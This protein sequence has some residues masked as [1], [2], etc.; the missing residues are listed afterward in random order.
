MFRYRLVDH[1]ALYQETARADHSA[2]L[3]DG[4]KHLRAA[5]LLLNGIKVAG[6]KT[7]YGANTSTVQLRPARSTAAT[8]W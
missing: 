5:L 6:M 1:A 2:T 7:S 3:V 4:I 8:K